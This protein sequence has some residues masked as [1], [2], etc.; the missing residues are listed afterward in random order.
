MKFLRLICWLWFTALLFSPL[1][2]Q[3][4]TWMT[5]YVTLDD[6]SNGTGYQ[7][8]SVAAV[9]PNRFV[10]LVTQTPLAPNE[11]FLFNVNGNYLVG[12]WDA[13]SVNGRVPSPINGQQTVP[14]YAVD[15]QYTDWTSGLDLVTLS[16]A[17]QIASGGANNF[18]YVANN[19]ADHNILVFEL[20]GTGLVST[21]YR[22]ATGSENIYA[23]EVDDNGY[24]YVCDYKGSAAKNNEIKVFAPIGTPGT[25]WGEPFVHND[26][27]VTVIDLPEGRYQGLTVSGDGTQLFV[28]KSDEYRILKFTGDPN[29]GYTLDAGWERQLTEADTI[30][31]NNG[32]VD[33]VTYLGLAYLNSPPSLY[34]AV[35]SFIYRG[36][37]GGYVYGRLH[38]IDPDGGWV[39][40]SIDI[41]KWN[42]D[43]TGSYSTG[44]SNGRV[45]G[46]TSVCDVDVEESEQAAYTQTFY[47]WAV[48]KWIFDGTLVGVEPVSGTIPQQFRLKQ[49]YPNPFNP[50]TTIEFDLKESAFVTLEVFNLVGQKVATLVKEQLQPG[51]YRKVFNAGNLPSGIYFYRMSAG[52]FTATYQMSLLK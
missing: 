8:S 50:S 26:A 16:G 38:R 41:A 30:P 44:S 9:G 35:D 22:M 24:V 7:T 15:G 1:F 13:D 5:Q 6:G 12:Y 49:N 27:P 32:T 37:T 17:W 29:S 4:N 34:A 46:F 19:D 14:Q 47:G 45:G 21:D 51:T 40:D 23:I 52:N 48:E 3:T 11:P 2:A 25:T 42:F 31:N 18:V 36:D 20:T 43:N 33:R 28:S 10:A 39:V